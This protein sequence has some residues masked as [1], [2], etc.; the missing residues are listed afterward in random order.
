MPTSALRAL[1]EEQIR[2]ATFADEAVAGL[3]T[4]P[5]WLLAKYFYDRAGSELFERITALP[6]YYPTRCELSILEEH[7]PQI[8]RLIPHGAALVE[9]GAGSSRKIRLVLRAAPHLGAY[10]PVDIS[11]DYLTQEA[12]R[13]QADFPALTILPVTGDFMQ[14]FELPDEVLA[15]ARVGF[16]PGSTIGNFEP[17]AATAFIRHAGQVL[18]P[19]AV[20]IVGVDLIKDEAVL[21]AA[22]N[23]AAG[24]T[25][26]FNLNL[27]ARMNREL[28]ADFD[29][30]NFSH[31]AFFNRDKSRV[32]MHLI[33]A[34]P[35]TV[36]V[37]GKKFR[38]RAGESIHT[39]S[40][41]KYSLDSF[42][43]LARSAGARPVAAW[44]DRDGYFSVHALMF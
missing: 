8:A 25:A 12:A 32:E 44:T 19:G 26:A 24:V 7:G 13:L 42:R 18:G 5:K 6:E 43:A 10:V 29:L 31:H 22:Y 34:R 2:L 35:Q 1:R 3:S 39:E 41:Y 28:G 38:F 23:D 17:R 30:D 40:S 33:S 4:S 27:L 15:R 14:A 11:G 9:F 16:F 21:H 20:L 37:A 36:R